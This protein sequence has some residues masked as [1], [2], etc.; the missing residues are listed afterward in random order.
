MEVFDELVQFLK[1]SWPQ[2]G[3]DS[4]TLQ[5]RPENTVLW[6]WTTD[7]LLALHLPIAR[8]NTALR[9]SLAQISYHSH[10]RLRCHHSWYSMPS[11]TGSC[12]VLPVR[13][14]CLCNV[15]LILACC[16]S[17][18]KLY[19]MV[20]HPYSILGFIFNI[21]RFLLGFWFRCWVLKVVFE[22]E[23]TCRVL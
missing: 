9:P 14:L 21:L 22:Y 11:E 13:S 4:L 7:V 15:R 16:L 20:P 17:P 8:N 12:C 19:W 2:A 3:T 18:A 10:N 1:V 5:T 6:C 23:T